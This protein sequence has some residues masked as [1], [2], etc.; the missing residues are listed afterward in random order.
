MTGKPLIHMVPPIANRL[1]S[2]HAQQTVGAMRLGKML[3]KQY[4]SSPIASPVAMSWSPQQRARQVR[5][6][7]DRL[8]I[9]FRT[10]LAPTKRL[11]IVNAPS[12]TKTHHR[13]PKIEYQHLSRGAFVVRSSPIL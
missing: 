4:P 12:P 2:L 1:A 6:K 11:D 3:P 8:Y 10:C 5:D 9:I 13:L 7:I